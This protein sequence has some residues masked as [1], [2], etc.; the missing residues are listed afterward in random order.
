[1]VHTTQKG[2]TQHKKGTHNTKRAHTTQK[3]YTHKN[4]HVQKFTRTKILSIQ[5]FWVRKFWGHKNFE[6]QKF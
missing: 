5:K 2:Y 1:M 6:A 4:F 3:G